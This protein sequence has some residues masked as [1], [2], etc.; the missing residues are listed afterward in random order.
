MSEPDQLP[1]ESEPAIADEWRRAWQDRLRARSTLLGAGV[2]LLLAF[3]LLGGLRW[4]WLLVGLASLIAYAGWFPIEIQQAKLLELP[5]QGA[6]S[7][8]SAGSPA[9]NASRGELPS[10][11]VLG[12][13]PDA[14][15]LLDGGLIVLAV[16]SLARSALGAEIGFHL[17]RLS[18][19]PELFA[20]CDR[21]LATGET[22]TCEFTMM[23]PIERHLMSLATPLG[24]AEDGG[25]S[26]LLVLRDLTEQDRLAQMRA[27]FVA[28]ASHELRTPLAALQGF[29]ETLQGAAKDDPEARD[30]FLAIMQVQA[31]RMSQLI[32]DLL[33]LSRVEMREHVP[34]KEAVDLVDVLEVVAADLQADARGAEIAVVVA[35]P[36]GSS[37]VLGDRDELIQVAQNLIQN[38]I[39]YGRPGGRVEVSLRGAGSNIALTVADDGIGIPP[40]HVP[41]LT[42][43]FYRV[44]AKDSRERGGTGLG[45]AI[46]KHIVN[47]HQGTLDIRST[48]GEGSVFTVSLP[49][50]PAATPAER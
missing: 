33:S 2:L 20:A 28:N 36:V 6:V 41:R 19:S 1:H 31:Q 21:A 49:K 4:P 22:Q 5:G 3:G 29:V 14:A 26:L 38:A 16:N 8:R 15:L 27:D 25:P 42:E 10:Q 44:S 9:A 37:T 39:K 18:R 45:L 40:D 50:A 43:R 7:H 34:P 12:G 48:V 24:G 47:R 17:A 46:V 11:A 32:E 23:A 35:P 30:R 13:L